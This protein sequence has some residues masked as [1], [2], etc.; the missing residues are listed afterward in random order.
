MNY[1]CLI[2]DDELELA[3]ATA[4]Y[5]NLF[6]VKTAF[7]SS[8]AEY[9][10]FAKENNTELILLDINLGD[11]SGFN[12][13]KEIRENSDVPILFVSARQ[14]DE[15]VLVALNIGGDDY[16][17]KP[18]SL[19]ILLA[20]V[21]AVLKRSGLTNGTLS[22]LQ[23]ETGLDEAYILHPEKFSVTSNGQE[24]SL[25]AREYALIE[26][27]VLNKGTIMT[28]DQLFEKVWGDGFYSDGTLNVHI[29]KLR[30]KLEDDPNNPKHIKTVWGTGYYYE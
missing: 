17:K 28:K 16:I 1:N 2:I 15:D 26:C 13:C 3:M 14:S 23:S 5:F 24:I 30:E 21:K 9:E 29:R 4:E 8:V 20:K 7:V 6:D 12:I 22:K 18:Y 25:K 11:E 10:N 19:S 27:L